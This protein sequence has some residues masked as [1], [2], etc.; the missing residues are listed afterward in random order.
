MESP[1]GGVRAPKSLINAC[2]SSGLSIFKIFT[3]TPWP[4]IVEAAGDKVATILPFRDL[5]DLP[6]PAC[7]FALGLCCAK[8]LPV[9]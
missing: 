2:V 1:H 6:C 8:T 7:L 5:N 9:A 4:S 3:L